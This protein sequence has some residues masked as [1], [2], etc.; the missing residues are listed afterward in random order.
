MSYY[1]AFLHLEGRP[2]LVVGGGE[3]AASKIAGLLRAGAEVTVVAPEIDESVRRQVTVGRV[4]YHERR[5]REGD[6]RGMRLAV[7]ATDDPATNRRVAADAEREGILLNVVDAP[8]LS[9]FIAPA[10][11]ERGALQIAVSTSGTAPAFAS[12][13]RDRLGDQIGPEYV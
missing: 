4:V 11:L 8:A 5:Y 12:G 7:A 2:C 1:P 10:V 3:V 13:L 9:T 6:L